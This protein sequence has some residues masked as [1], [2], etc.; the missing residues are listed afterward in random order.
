MGNVNDSYQVMVDHAL[1]E[2]CL[3]TERHEMC[4]EQHEQMR[5]AFVTGDDALV[6]RLWDVFMRGG[7]GHHTGKRKA[8]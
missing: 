8:M 6:L 5:Q 3:A 4:E 7:E 2:A 1:T